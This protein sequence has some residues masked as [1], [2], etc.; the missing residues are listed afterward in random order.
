MDKFENLLDH[1]I[2][3]LMAKR[4]SL[5]SKREMIA[6]FRGQRN[7]NNQAISMVATQQ[8]SKKKDYP[9]A[10]QVM[11]VLRQPMD[12]SPAEQQPAKPAEATQYVFIQTVPW[13]E[14]EPFKTLS[15]LTITDWLLVVIAI[16]L[17][18]DIIRRK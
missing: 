11:A 7:R 6:Y 17:L 18:I 15:K 8:S 2:D 14:L 3:E 1:S 10:A 16:L 4:N 12:S 13:T 9:D 5:D